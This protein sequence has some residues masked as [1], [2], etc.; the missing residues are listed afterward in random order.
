MVILRFRMI[1]PRR[2][3]SLRRFWSRVVIVRFQTVQITL[4]NT[5]TIIRMLSVLFLY[6]ICNLLFE[7][8]P[9]ATD[10]FESQ[11]KSLTNKNYL[12]QWSPRSKKLT[13]K[14]KRPPLVWAFGTVCAS[15]KKSQKIKENNYRSSL[16]CHFSFLVHR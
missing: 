8:S 11:F 15:V 12:S 2:T 3:Y 16:F 7:K 1:S 13:R 6:I 14:L 4:F 9:F 5:K 10:L